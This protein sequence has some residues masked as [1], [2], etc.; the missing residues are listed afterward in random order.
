[1]RTLTVRPSAKVNL[2]LRVGPLR[3]DGFHDVRTLLQSIDLADTLRLTARRGAFAFTCDA[4]DVPADARN[5][6]WRAARALWAAAGR[7]GEPRDV[8]L[9]LTKRIPHAAGLGGGSADAAAALVALNRLW[10]L[11][12]PVARLRDVAATIGAD[13]AFFLVGGTALGA[14]K[15]E[16]LYPVSDVRRLGLV[17]VKPAFGI[18]TAEAYGWVDADRAAGRPAAAGDRSGTLDVGWASGPVTVANDME[19]PAARR[20]PEIA[21]ILETCV[22]AGAEA[23]ALSGSGSAVFAVVSPRQVARVARAVAGAGRRVWTTR[24]LTRREALRRIGL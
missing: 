20:H 15:G 22:A 23:A 11:R 12:L 21:Q 19:A 1:M 17:I 7:P 14:G 2:V 5:L 8:A 3:P 6:V 9:H 4:P 16:D 13:V 18:S 24:T 10:M